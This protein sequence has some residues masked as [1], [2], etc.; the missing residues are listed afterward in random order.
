MLN[1]IAIRKENIEP[2]EKRSP[3][4]P[5]HINELVK[6]SKIKMILEPWEN[7]HF[8]HQNYID[9][10]AQ[11]SK[12]L[13]GANI[14]FGVKEIP[15]KDLPEKQAAVFFSHTIKGQSYNMPLLQA[16]LDKNVTLMDYE[17]VTDESGKRLIFFG[18]YAGLAGAINSIWLLGQRL[19][20]EGIENPFQNMKQANTYNS[21]DDAKSAL[22]QI[23]EK[24][25][26]NGL[27]KTGKPWV[28]V[29]TGAGTVSKGAQEIV[30]LLPV[31]EVNPAE[32]RQ[33]QKDKSFDLN[34]LYKVV[35]D[36]DNFVKPINENDSF[37]WD[38]YFSMPEKYESDFAQYIPDITV[39]I[40]CIFWD[41]MY[42]KLVTKNDIKNLHGKESQPNL[43][44]IADIT[45]DVEGSIECNQK[46]TASDNPT[47][48]FDAFKQTIQDGVEG[49][50]PVILAVDKLPSELPRE[51]TKFF[52][53]LLFP[54]VPELA[55]AN[56][57]VPFEELV[58]PAPFKKAMIT[59]Q[60][61]LTPDYEYLKK[62]L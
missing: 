5:N 49:N 40:N 26:I 54:F 25:K 24:I 10:G 58:L 35:I 11:I 46:S 45:C 33:L 16:V 42:P 44:I 22:A 59:H 12:D 4:S 28:F 2:T 17:K 37:G 19:K 43:R 20:N 38:D 31:K 55:K 7:R 14:I 27:P 41:T 56:F 61:K 1:T 32:F 18:P 6:N 52:G 13:T 51:A 39:L 34:Q 57:T 3:L 8:A 62:Y 9:N 21:L 50:G 36:C 15:I 30:D 48:V 47:Y 29:I 23:S 53:D 60:G